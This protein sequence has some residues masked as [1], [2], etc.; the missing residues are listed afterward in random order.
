MARL[1]FY[2]DKRFKTAVLNGEQHKLYYI[3]TLA[4]RIN[5]TV[6]TVRN[7]E[8]DGIIPKSGFKDKV[9]RRLYTREQIEAIHH[10]VKRDRVERGRCMSYTNF[11]VHCHRHF[12][13]L[14]N[15]YFGG[16]SN[17]KI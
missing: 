16:N 11:S 8:H 10:W 5:R 13:E 4:K 7:W 15:K 1:A 3:G 6:D 12:E 14:H 9:G 17:G 2:D